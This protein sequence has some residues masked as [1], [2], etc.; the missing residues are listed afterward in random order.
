[1]S[2]AQRNR[3]GWIDPADQDFTARVLQQRQSDYN[4]NVYVILLLENDVIS[5]IRRVR[6]S[7]DL[8]S[9]QV[10]FMNSVVNVINQRSG[11]DV[12][13]SSVARSY[14]RLL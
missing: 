7:S 3:G 14:Y 2:F 10:S 13:S 9:G 8:T 1:M 4:R 11:V 5:Q 12:S 6:N